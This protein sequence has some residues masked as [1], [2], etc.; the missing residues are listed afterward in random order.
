[1][2]FQ[3]DLPERMPAMGAHLSHQLLHL[4]QEG[5][6]NALKHAQAVSIRLA[7]GEKDGGM[8]LEIEDDGLGFDQEQRPG[9]AEWHFGLQGM[10]ERAARLG[11]TFGIDSVAGEGT[12]IR[13]TLPMNP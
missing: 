10:K 9:P 13:V 11:G 1:M 12:R 2:D 5:V 4:A 8:R 7:L 6:T 3:L